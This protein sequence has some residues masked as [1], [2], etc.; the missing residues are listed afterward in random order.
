MLWNC[1]VFGWMLDNLVITFQGRACILLVVLSSQKLYLLVKQADTKK[2][3]ETVVLSKGDHIVGNVLVHPTAKI[4][5]NC[6]IGPNVVIGSGVVIGDGVRLSRSVIMSNSKI[7]DHAWINSSIIGWRCNIGRW[8][9]IQN[10]SILGDDVSLQ[11]EIFLNGATVLPH[12]SVGSNVLQP[13]IIMQL[14]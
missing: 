2:E 13:K 1:L 7:K 4:G 14:K 10:T 9:R 5:N 6:K 3:D 12:K 11:D 8:T